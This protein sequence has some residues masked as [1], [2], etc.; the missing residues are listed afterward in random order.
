MP[1]RRVVKRDEIYKRRAAAWERYYSL[2]AQAR[3]MG[4]VG[5]NGEAIAR[6]LDCYKHYNTPELGVD[7]WL[8]DIPLETRQAE[9]GRLLSVFRLHDHELLCAWWWTAVGWMEFVRK[10]NGLPDVTE[11]YYYRYQPMPLDR[12]I[13]VPMSSKPKRGVG[14]R[15]SKKVQVPYFIS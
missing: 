12:C 10:F 2:R 9:Q 5:W 6:T 13:L 3:Q 7:G 11:D 1:R 14:I 8:L 15:H 4:E